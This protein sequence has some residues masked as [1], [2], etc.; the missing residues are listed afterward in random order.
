MT[1]RRLRRRKRFKVLTGRVFKTLAAEK[2]GNSSEVFAQNVAQSQV[3][4]VRINP[5]S[6]FPVALV[7]SANQPDKVGCNRFSPRARMNR[8]GLP[9]EP[10]HFMERRSWHRAPHPLFPA[11]DLFQPEVLQMKE[12]DRPIPRES[13]P[14]QIVAPP[15]DRAATLAS[16]QDDHE[17][18]S[19]SLP[20]CC[21]QPGESALLGPQ[22]FRKDI[23]A[24]R[25]RG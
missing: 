9:E 12:S 2:R 13:R 15:R 22:E 6:C 19:A 25:N 18:R 4:S 1:H 5:D 24:E 8:Y 20:I 17:Y 3:I 7:T 16:G 23:P 10:L 21:D 14:G 11:R